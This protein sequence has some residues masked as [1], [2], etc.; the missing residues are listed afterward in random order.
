[1]K[2]S[3][4]EH[5]RQLVLIVF[6][7][8]LGIFLSERIEEN[9]QAREAQLLLSRLQSE[10]KDNQKLL[11]YWVPYHQAI[12]DR[13][14]SLMDQDSFV[15]AFI[16]D[17][18]ALFE[19]VLTRGNLMGDA[20]AGDAWDIAKSHPLIVHFDYDAL[21]ILSIMTLSQN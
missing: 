18:S 8:V 17:Q 2:T 14:D 9:Q 12:V 1:M 11:E 15:Q 13:L 10:I 6:S 5:I 3:V 4:K 20:P 7:V 16:A 19:Q 21:L